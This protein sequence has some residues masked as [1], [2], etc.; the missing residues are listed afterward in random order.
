MGKQV[1][2]FH[3]PQVISSSN[4]TFC[5]CKLDPSDTYTRPQT[6]VDIIH[7]SRTKRCPFSPR[8]LEPP[9]S[10]TQSSTSDLTCRIPALVI[11]CILSTKTLENYLRTEK[12][13]GQKPAGFFT[14][15]DYAQD[16]LALG[17]VFNPMG[18]APGGPDLRGVQGTA[19]VGFEGKAEERDQG[20][21]QFKER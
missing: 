9:N 15:C 13:G 2:F 7:C 4:F 17:S 3:V 12:Q 10:S 8:M 16:L 18:A 14:L 20:M 21:V 11:H 6:Y 5:D 1:K 19:L